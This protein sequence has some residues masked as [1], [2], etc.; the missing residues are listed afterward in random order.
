MLVPR[1]TAT[2]AA[3][4]YRPLAFADL[5]R[6]GDH[7]GKSSLAEHSTNWATVLRW[8]VY[9]RTP[10]Q[11]AA[12]RSDGALRRLGWRG[13]GRRT[14]MVASARP[15]RRR[16]APA[17]ASSVGWRRR[18][19]GRAGRPQ[20]PKRAANK[21]LPSIM[22]ANTGGGAG[23]APFDQAWPLRAPGAGTMTASR[24]QPRSP[25]RR[26]HRLPDGSIAAGTGRRPLTCRAPPRSLRPVI[27]RL[28]TRLRPRRP[29]GAAC[30]RRGAA[31]PL[32]LL[33]RRRH[34]RCSVRP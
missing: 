16:T 4:D 8:L 14:A 10:R 2:V 9:F 19:C 24:T 29:G 21:A 22:P 20:G 30:A 3:H 25:Q 13:R 18:P 26:R 27:R 31:M 34:W 5:A 33:C 6:A 12:N 17:A 1:P 11:R 28:H 23:P 32:D 15:A 7:P